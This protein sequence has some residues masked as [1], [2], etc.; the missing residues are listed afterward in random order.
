[1][2]NG[3]RKKI[4]LTE[5]QQHW[6]LILISQPNQ[7][8]RRD[9]IRDK[10]RRQCKVFLSQVAKCVSQNHY[11]EIIRHATSLTWVFNLIK[12]DY[13]L[14]V[15]GIDFLNLAGIKYESETMTPAAFYQ[16]VKSHITANTTRA[17]QVIQHNNN[18]QQTADETVGPCFQDYIL[19]NTIR[20]WP[21]TY[22]AYLGSQ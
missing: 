5:Y 9:S 17:G 10:R 4:I 22:K 18:Q 8:R 12:Q 21:L 11:L 13:D 6:L 20:D 2:E 14:R 7:P 1:M 3:S 15:T 19:Y 16:K